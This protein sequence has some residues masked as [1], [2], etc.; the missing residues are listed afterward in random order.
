MFDYSRK[1]SLRNTCT[2]GWETGLSE[3]TSSSVDQTI[4]VAE[5]M[6]I[7]TLPAYGKYLKYLRVFGY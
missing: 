1:K 2:G 4:R 5:S 6:G 7:A 3:W